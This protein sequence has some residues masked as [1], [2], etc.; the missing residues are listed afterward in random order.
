VV[1]FVVASLVAAGLGWVLVRH[2]LPRVATRERA[3]VV[4]GFAAV[5][6]LALVVSA[7]GLA[8]EHLRIA[9]LQK[10]QPLD[11]LASV[12]AH[13]EDEQILVAGRIAG[14]AAPLLQDYVAFVDTSE[15]G[16]ARTPDLPVELSDGSVITVDEPYRPVAWPTRD[17]WYRA[18]KAG[19]PVVVVG[20]AVA[21]ASRLLDESA[22]D[23][24]VMEHA[25]V[26]QGSPEGFRQDYV[27]RMGPAS[28]FALVWAA[29]CQIAALVILTVPIPTAWRTLRSE[30]PA[31]R[32]EGSRAS[33][34]PG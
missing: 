20:D 5:L 17:G 6:A 24:A 32:A 22:I 4:L 7:I 25:L 15:G 13:R 21:T 3:L 27:S 19:D 33:R 18:V 14:S 12:L 30:G 31:A 34:P 2:A 8:S 16:D 28:V 23:G 9:S 1:G 29:F 11:T 10:L 26:Y